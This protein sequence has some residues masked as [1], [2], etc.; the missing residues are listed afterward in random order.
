MRRTCRFHNR[1]GFTILEFLVSSSILAVLSAIIIPAVQSAR[2]A[3]RKVSCRNNL[4]QVGIGLQQYVAAHGQFPKTR[5]ATGSSFVSL[6]PWLD[7][8]SMYSAIVEASRTGKRS[9]FP[10]PGVFVCPEDP[11]AVSRRRATSIGENVGICV[12][13]KKKETPVGREYDG[14]FLT[15]MQPQIVRP[16]GVTDGMSNTA[17]YAE[18]VGYPRP[19][20]RRMVY[21]FSSD[22][23]R[24][25]AVQE[26]ATHC[27]MADKALPSNGPIRRGS[28]WIHGGLQLNQY[29]HVLPPN[30]RECLFIPNA[31]SEHQAGAHT[32]MCDGS[33]KFVSS[34]VDDAVWQAAGSRN[35]AEPLSQF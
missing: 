16:A 21:S 10:Q 27:R 34:S 31:A 28:D 3:S 15:H 20:R 2:G 6:L 11:V 26:L 14:I 5:S 17:C 22:G 8:A 7:Q 35:G 4:R 24:C 12:F 25:R 23:M 29:Q 32:A 18:I 19:D 9:A 13:E 30:E 1:S 33:V